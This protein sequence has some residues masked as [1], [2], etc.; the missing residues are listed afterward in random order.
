MFSGRIPR[1][2]VVALWTDAPSA[3]STVD[4]REARRG[5]RDVAAGDIVDGH[6]E[7]IH[8]RRAEE[9]G[10]E[11]IV[12]IAIEFQR[13][14]DLLDRAAIEHDDPARHG[15]RLDLVVGDVDHGRAE[16]GMQAAELDAHLRAQRG[17]EVRQRFVEQEDIGRT[18]DRA[19]DRDALALA[20]G[21]LLRPLFELVGDPAGSWRRAPR[22]RRS[23]PSAA[24]AMR[25]PK[26]MFSATVICG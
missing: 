10:D 9:A 23:R 5:D 16:L 22:P 19:T 18:G 17:V 6:L 2:S 7:E 3:S 14:A 12:G 20:A 15:H 26:P 1:V 8:P 24:C 4:R 21:K 13:R 25:R 11:E